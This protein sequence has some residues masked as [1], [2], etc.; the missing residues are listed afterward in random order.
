MDTAFEKE[1]AEQIVGKLTA[2]DRLIIHGHLTYFFQHAGFQRFL[3]QQGVLLKDF[4]PYVLNATA[5]VR[6]HALK[7]AGEAQRPYMHLNYALKGK[8]E[9]AKKIAQ[10]DGITEGLIC[11]LSTLEVGWSFDVKGNHQTHKLNIVRR[12][13]K[14]L[15]WYF[16]FMDPEFGFIH[17]RLQSWFPFQIQMY[18]NGREWLGRQL[19]RRGI[20]FR[21]YENALVEVEDLE[22][23]QEIADRLGQR[24]WPR[25]LDALAQRINP[26][27][28]V[29]RRYCGGL[30]YYWVVDQCEIATD[31]LWK[32]RESLSAVMPDLLDHAICT[33]SPDSVMRF[34]G[35]KL[36]GHFKGEA[37]SDDRKVP[38]T[39]RGRPEGRRVKH[40]I[41]GNWIKFYDKWN[42]L[43]V[44]TV[45]NKPSDFRILRVTTTSRGRKKRRWMR[46]A[47]GVA[48]LWRYVQVGRQSNERYLG[49]LAQ[50]RVQGKAVAE[51]DRLCQSRLIRGRRYARFHPVSEPDFVL[52]RAVLAGEHAIHGFRNRNVCAR[53]HPKPAA[54]SE[55]ARRRCARVSRLIAKLRGHG[56]VAKVPRSR[57]YRITERGQRLMSA[58]VHYRQCGLPVALPRVA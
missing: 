15:H 29:L 17:L 10:R 16:Y 13:R 34:L 20:G 47:K 14:C 21:R 45:I 23:A 6:A 4:K 31:I 35:R 12:P 36:T 53:L 46:M 11:V 22:R 48:N 25:L 58:A 41:A 19:D 54:S 30:G 52:F 56:L 3:Y 18:L 7:M 5:R 57:L 32:S 50:A 51:L 27:L 9:L 43:R 39:L 38:I 26:L 24:K 42:V 8:D 28:P 40:R 33:F 2:V 44:E 1:Y 55:E 37:V 49:A